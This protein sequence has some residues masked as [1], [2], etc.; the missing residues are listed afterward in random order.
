MGGRTTCVVLVEYGNVL[1]ADGGGAQGTLKASFVYEA[2]ER[3]G[4]DATLVGGSFQVKGAWGT[5]ALRL[6]CKAVLKAPI[7]RARRW[8]G[9]RALY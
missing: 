5:P 1:G 7:P 2:H 8:V 9:A 6:R 4:H 3:E